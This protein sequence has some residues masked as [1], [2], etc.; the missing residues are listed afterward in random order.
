M[1]YPI[2]SVLFIA[3]LVIYLVYL[4]FVKKDEKLFFSVLYPGIFFVSVW[5]LIYYFLL[6]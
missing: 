2:L 1:F 5:L 3:L 6:M 4:Y